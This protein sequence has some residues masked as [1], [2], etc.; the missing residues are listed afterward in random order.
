[1]TIA[2]LAIIASISTIDVIVSLFLHESYKCN[3]WSLNELFL[4]QVMGYDLSKFRNVTRWY[5][6]TKSTAPKYEEC[7]GA[8]AKAFKAYADELMK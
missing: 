7:N 5:A 2:D 6:K 8:G 3:Y 1:M 4:E